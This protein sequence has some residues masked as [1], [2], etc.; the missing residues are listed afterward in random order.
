MVY[1]S[2]AAPNPP[3][4][5]Q[6]IT[7]AIKSWAEGGKLDKKQVSRALFVVDNASADQKNAVLNLFKKLLGG[8]YDGKEF[9]ARLPK[10]AKA[11]EGGEKAEAKEA[12]EKPDQ[13]VEEIASEISQNVDELLASVQKIEGTMEAKPE[14]TPEEVRKRV[15]QLSKELAILNDHDDKT[16]KP[17]TDMVT[18]FSDAG[19]ISKEEANEILNLRSADKEFQEKTD[20]LKAKIGDK[21]T[22]KLVALMKETERK[23]AQIE[24]DFKKRAKEA[25]AI[26]EKLVEKVYEKADQEKALETLSRRAGFPVQKGTRLRYKYIK[27]VGGTPPP[28]KLETW[29]N[30]TITDVSFDEI[31]V[32]DDNGKVVKK[33]PSLSPKIN[34]DWDEPESNK[35]VSFNYTEVQFLKNVDIQDI[36]P[37]VEGLTEESLKED[38]RGKDLSLE[39]LIGE[40]INAGDVFEYRE[41]SVDLQNRPIGIDKKVR[42]LAI[43]EKK[44]EITLDQNVLTA[45]Y[46]EKRMEKILS[47]GGF[48]KWYRRMEAVKEVKGLK[49]LRD[50][51]KDCRLPQQ[52]FV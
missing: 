46:P 19:K 32:Y 21:E 41:K 2:R 25:A 26:M 50:R 23:T 49:A 31:D 3:R 8:D 44:Q 14:A 17:L 22:E 16:E 12:A 4:T 51:L 40:K 35:M 20:K 13:K 5:L 18:G 28:E 37:L 10:T 11:K 9:L 30:A 7:S 33:A 48:A 29:R 36:V 27:D 1:R 15:K 43:D 45:E 38:Q 24:E 39:A 42:V 6:W 47:Y 34:V 52:R